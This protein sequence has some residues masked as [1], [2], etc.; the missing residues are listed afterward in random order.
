MSGAPELLALRDE[1]LE[2]AVLSLVV[3]A[4]HT[5]HGGVLAG[6]ADAAA[7]FSAAVGAVLALLGLLIAADASRR[8]RSRA[9]RRA[10]GSGRARYILRA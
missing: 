2:A 7:A 1:A 3:N 5:S 8:L 4:G 10:E 6:A 9:L